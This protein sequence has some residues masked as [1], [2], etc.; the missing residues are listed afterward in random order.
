MSLQLEEIEHRTPRCV[1]RNQTPSPLRFDRTVLDGWLVTYNTKRPDHGRSMK[2]R[3]PLKAFTNG[4]KK[5]ATASRI[6]PK[7][8]IS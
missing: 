4:L 6:K 7:G 1:G 2:G 3:M 5:S 8:E